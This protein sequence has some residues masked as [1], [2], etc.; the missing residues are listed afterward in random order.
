[1][2]I[3]SASIRSKFIFLRKG[4]SGHFVIL[5]PEAMLSIVD[6]LTC[7]LGQMSFAYCMFCSSSF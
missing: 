6:L 1:M 4:K 3:S 5:Y 7:G 2:K